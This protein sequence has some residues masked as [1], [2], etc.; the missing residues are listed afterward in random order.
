MSAQYAPTTNFGL[1]AMVRGEIH[2]RGPTCDLN[3]IEVGYITDFTDIFA[4][5]PFNGDVSSWDVA[6]GGDFSGMFRDSPFNG[7]VSKW[8][9]ANAENFSNMFLNSKFNGD[10]SNWDVRSASN[11]QGMFLNSSFAGDVSRWGVGNVR[12]VVGMFLGAPFDGDVRQ[13]ALHPE[14]T[15]V[16]RLLDFVAHPEPGARKN[17]R[18]PVF[19]VE[20]F[21]LF[22]DPN[23]MHAWLAQRASNDDIDRYHWDALLRLPSA[24]WATPEMRQHLQMY[25]TLSGLASTSKEDLPESCIDHSAALALSWAATHDRCER[26]ELPC[27]DEGCAP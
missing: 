21:R 26:I 23:T 20:G 9:V 15:G 27:L 11:M 7:D 1:R 4:E 13:W 25:T 3:H 12:N 22:L 10:V 24:S 16:A 2:R 6:R 14:C 8:N 17:L 19:P 5:T 18:L